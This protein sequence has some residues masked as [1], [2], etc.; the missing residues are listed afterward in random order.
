MAQVYKEYNLGNNIQ[1]VTG[2]AISL[3][4]TDD[5]QEKDCCET[6]DRIQLYKRSINQYGVSPYLYPLYGL[7]E[8]P[9]G[10]ARLSA[11]YGGTY[12]LNKP[13]EKVEINEEGKVCV[14]SEG[15]TVRGK[16]VVGD[17]SY[18][19]DRV[20]K[21]GKV[22]R[23]ICILDHTIQNTNNSLSCQ[24]ILPQSQ[25]NRKHDI[26]IGCVSF[27]HNVAAKGKYLAIVSTEVETD[28]PLDEVKVAMNLLEPVMEQ[29]VSVDDLYEPLEDGT[30][31]KV[32]ISKSYD[33]TSHFETTCD[34]ILDIYKRVLGREF[35]FSNEEINQNLAAE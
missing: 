24:I 1:D 3:N 33:A 10:F 18:F 19:P 26:Y 5:Y 16:M 21:T 28:N 35:E 6:F 23:V 31:D 32:F 15:E 9:Q 27:A 12:M 30:K 11:I 17:P 22:I 29:F 20:K 7:G 2:H 25:L 14:T 13:I 8:L 34:D 4:T